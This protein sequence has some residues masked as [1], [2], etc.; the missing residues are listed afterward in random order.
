MNKHLKDHIRQ[1]V[2]QAISDAVGNQN[3]GSTLI[4]ESIINDDRWKIIS[5]GLQLEENTEEE[6]ARRI[7]NVS[8]KI[9]EKGNNKVMFVVSPQL[10]KFEAVE[11]IN[12]K[13]N[14]IE[15]FDSLQDLE[16]RLTELLYDGYRVLEREGTFKQVLKGLAVGF[17]GASAGMGGGYITA[18]ILTAVNLWPEWLTGAKA[19]GA[20]FVAQ[21]AFTTSALLFGA[22]L[23]AVGGGWYIFKELLAKDRRPN[24]TDVDLD[25]PDIERIKR[26]R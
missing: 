26:I 7:K 22:G 23:I 3:K 21:G 17:A 25:S 10:N 13:V 24:P 18:A 20:A 12:G 1:Q 9:V 11:Y 6:L 16:N 4:N 15:Q 8:M 19:I 14:L 2:R 5:E